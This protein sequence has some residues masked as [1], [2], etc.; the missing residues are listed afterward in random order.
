MEPGW[1]IRISTDGVFDAAPFYRLVEEID[2]KLYRE[3]EQSPEADVVARFDDLLSNSVSLHLA[4]DA[5]LGV[6]VS[7]GLDSS[8]VT[9]MAIPKMSLAGAY[10]AEVTGNDL[11]RT[12]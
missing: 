5:R 3:L 6:M 9:R 2:P 11:K 12:G 10:H 7:G 1:T 8:L 4:S